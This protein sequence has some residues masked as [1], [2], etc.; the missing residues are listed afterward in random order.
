VIHETA[1]KA[2]SVHINL[3]AA[4]PWSGLDVSF[5]SKKGNKFH[6]TLFLTQKTFFEHFSTGFRIRTGITTRQDRAYSLEH[7]HEL[8]E[9][10][11][12]EW[13]RQQQ[14]D[15]INLVWLS[16]V[17]FLLVSSFDGMRG[18][19]VVWTDLAALLRDIE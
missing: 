17:M 12:S 16:A 5:A 2:R 11:E 3:W 4:S 8:L 10:F 6:A 14:A 9:Y 15:A 19:K 13:D 1:R 18:Y 7:I